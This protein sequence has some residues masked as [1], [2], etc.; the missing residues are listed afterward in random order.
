MIDVFVIILCLSSSGLQAD[1]KHNS[2][3]PDDV[4]LVGGASRCAGRLE[5]KHG[6]WRPGDDWDWTLQAAAAVCRRLDCG[7]AVSTEKKKD[8][9]SKSVWWVKPDCLQSASVVETCLS[10][11]SSSFSLQITCSDSV[12]LVDGN[13]LCSG[14]VEV[15][16]GQSWS[17]VCEADFD[18]QDAE[19]LCRELG[20]GAPSVLQGALYGEAEAPTW[21]K[22]FQ[23]EGSESVLLECG[24]SGS[25][26]NTCSPG[27]AVGLT[28]SE[29]DD[30][31]LVDGASRCAGR[32]EVKQHGD[33]K[34]VDEWDSDWDLRAVAAVCRQLDCGSAVS[35]EKKQDSSDRSVWEIRPDCLQAGS[36]MRECSVT[37]Q[38]FSSSSLH[39]TCSESVRLVNGKSLCS[40]RVEVKSG[41]SWSSV[42]EADF[43]QQDAEV[44]CREL[45]CGAPSVLQG[46][47]YGEAEA[48]TW[49]KEFQCEG[50][51]SVLLECGSSGSVRNTCS[52]GKAVG[53]TCSEPDDVR[54]VGG[55]S[56]CAGT[57][58]LK[59]HGDWK[60]V[61]DPH[62][63]WTLKLAV[64]V[65]RQ[66]DC[67]SAVSIEKQ[68]SSDRSVWEVRPDCLQA[69]SALRECLKMT[70][71]SSSHSL[72]TTC[73][74]SVRLVN[75]NS[76]CSGRVEVKSGQSWSSVCEADFDQQDAEVLCRE[77]G[78]G[79][80]SV[81]QGALYGEAEAP[82]WTK[83]FQ[84]E[85]SESVLLECGSSG[86][87]R[88]TCSP[89]KAVGLTCS[90]P[91]DV[92]L[93]GGA[94]R[95]AGTMEL[96]QHGDWK[97]VDVWNNDWTLQA[98]AA[99]CRQLDCGSAVS[100]DRREDS[101]D[102]T[103]W[104]IEPHCD[105]SESALRECVVKMGS[106]SRRSSLEVICSDVLV[107][108]IISLSPSVGGVSEAQQQGLQV[109]RGSSFSIGCSI[110]PQ[111]AGG[112]FQLTFTSSNATHTHTLPAVNHSAHF[113]FPAA[114][115]AHQGSY[116]CVY[117]I[118]VLSHHLS[119]E[120]QPLSLSV[121]GSPA[122]FIIRLVVLLLVL[123][124]MNT[125]LYLY[126][127]ATRG[128]RAEASRTA[129][130]QDI[131]LDYDEGEEAA[132]RGTE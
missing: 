26:R 104:V 129:G 85:G 56:R 86:S 25:V 113:L 16:S 65:C 66:L 63:D 127:K 131:E 118:D 17:S 84:C 12:R 99:V 110:Q 36:A 107:Q 11:G 15:K 57:M 70:S 94:S 73:S 6:D 33:W 39:I 38:M 95:C 19:V 13:S 83:E 67:G 121:S 111:Y 59:Q 4:R 18:Q 112:S 10:Q 61:D 132:A 41:Q 46:A 8:S 122:D 68:D 80:P 97:P 102:H 126:C 29:P 103:V 51:E 64:A 52:P 69:G 120:S 43:D 82:T 108:P 92:R 49:T 22:E 100:A 54:L 48:P 5:L 105:G 77:L 37:T 45:G 124:L 90:E 79:A 53:L 75:G 3:E 20:C 128:Q 119:S 50:S 115:P 60:P 42:C 130:Q 9:S 123:V 101:A 125:A 116:S 89:G 40:G 31:R 28:C 32:L 114:E 44:L 35:I 24:S 2:S 34:P 98:A 55:A 21:T 58:E 78:C 93:V 76:L 47:L 81:L 27:K 62:Y 74:D 117:H 91:D 106:Y 88:N 71:E 7:S 1:G 87:V 23:C 96:K 72:H 109:F 14:R 30:V